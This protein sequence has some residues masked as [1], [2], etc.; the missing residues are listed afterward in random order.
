MYYMTEVREAIY[1]DIEFFYVYVEESRIHFAR[2][3]TLLYLN[4]CS[5]DDK[6]AAC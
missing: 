1:R 4:F 6:N 3:L 2:L 5:F